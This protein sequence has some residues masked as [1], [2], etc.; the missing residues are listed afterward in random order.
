MT[1]EWRQEAACRG[2]NPER[3][4]PTDTG[5]QYGPK[6]LAHQRHVASLIAVCAECPVVYECAVDAVQEGATGCV[7]GGVDLTGNTWASGARKALR[8]KHGPIPIMRVCRWCST[9]FPCE[10][11]NVGYCSDEHRREAHAAQVE[12]GREMR[13]ERVNANRRADG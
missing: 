4:F 8:A 12:A 10:M 7:R 11:T 3:W 9:S 5:G 2:D 13:R 6:R 1:E